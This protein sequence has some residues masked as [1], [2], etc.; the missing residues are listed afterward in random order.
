MLKQVE[1][2]PATLILTEFEFVVEGMRHDRRLVQ[3][4]AHAAARRHR[5]GKQAALYVGA[6]RIAV[7][8]DR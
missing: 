7:V 1:A 8:A 5:P 3:A 4:N 2:H 6:D